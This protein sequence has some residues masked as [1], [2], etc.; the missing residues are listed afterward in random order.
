MTLQE[1]AASES[2]LGAEEEALVELSAKIIEAAAADGASDIHINP[3]PR[4][5]TVRF[6]IDGVLQ[7]VLT[8]PKNVHDPLLTRFKAMADLDTSNRRTVQD[9]RILMNLRGQEYDLRENVIPSVLGEKATLRLLDKV[10]GLPGLERLGYREED[11]KRLE[12]PLRAPSGVIIFSGPSG[13]GKTT[14][15]YAAL[16][17]IAR[18]EVNIMTIED[19]VEYSLPGMVQIGVNKKMGLTFPVGLRGILRSDP[20]I[21]FVGAIRDLETAE[22]CFQAA[23]TGHLVMSQLHATTA[24]G[25]IER[26]LDMGIEPFVISQGL[27]LAS[28]QRLVRVLCKDCREKAKYSAKFLSDLRKRA[29]AEG[30][31]WPNKPPVFYQA[32]G[33]EKCRK[34]GHW[35]RIAVFEMLPMDHEIAC[36]TAARASVEEIRQAAI[37][38]GMTTMF[39]D[40]IYKAMTGEISVEEVLRV[41]SISL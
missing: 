39:A 8:L 23:M 34:T 38:K 30:L 1:H 33:C 36:M 16:Q 37:K 10:R 2:V 17:H 4:E 24:A 19:P 20:D 40:G 7:D 5:T 12:S 35:R 31:I 15:A 21:I 29:E 28:A 11:R 14:H 13:S 26:L 18:P 9:G 25:V 6:R 22:L 41:L 3:T 27:I 32:K